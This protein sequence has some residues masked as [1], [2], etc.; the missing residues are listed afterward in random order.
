M[1]ARKQLNVKFV[2][3]E[4]QVGGDK[5]IFSMYDLFVLLKYVTIYLFM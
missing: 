1:V 4:E 5:I 2:P 3:S